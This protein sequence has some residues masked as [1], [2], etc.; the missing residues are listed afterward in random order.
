[1]RNAIRY[2]YEL[3]V[4]HLEYKDFRYSFGEYTLLELER[5]IPIDI[6]QQLKSWHYPLYDIIPNKSQ[7]LVTM[8]EDKQYVLL[9]THENYPVCL[10]LLERFQIPMGKEE[11]LPWHE[12]WMNKVDYYEKYTETIS[13]PKLINSF[14][15]YEG[16]TENAI[17][18][19][20][21]IKKDTPLYIAHDRMNNDFDYWNPINYLLDYRV[22]DVSEYVKVK[23]F[24][25]NF[26]MNDLFLYFRRTN[27]QTQDYL[28]FYA[29][30]LYPS[31][32]FDCY[33]CIVKGGEDSCLDRYL[34]KIEEYE[35]FLRDL[36]FAFQPFVFLPKIDW[37][38]D[39]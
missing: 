21:M 30:M 31:Y 7:E 15:Y 33:D 23:F 39:K 11:I 28:L 1:M 5:E 37:I 27:F 24:E 14:F 9:R 22:R 6:Y 34:E 8:I 38:V 2:Y 26:S 19:Y 4:N 32:Y 13:N 18:F 36:Y 17:S 10:E 35:F 20:Q 25:G 12:R 16:M 3:D 29:R